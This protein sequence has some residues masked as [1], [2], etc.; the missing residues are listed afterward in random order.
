MNFFRHRLSGLSALVVLC[1]AAGCSSADDS[2]ST[3]VPSPSAKAAEICGKLDAALPATVD[4]LP[5]RDPEPASPLTAGWGD[6]AIILRCGV[7]KPPKM[8]DKNADAGEADGVGWLVEKQD[9][10]TIRFTSALRVV[11][12]EVTLPKSRAAEGM[13]P[14]IDLA[15][16]VKKTVPEGIAD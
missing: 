16:A 13:S 11:Y 14:L 6:P 3:V 8:D 1:A 9:N 4:G 12:I 2:A 7:V 5:R 15:P 10:G